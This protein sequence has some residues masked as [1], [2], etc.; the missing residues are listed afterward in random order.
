MK[1]QEK[2]TRFDR[3]YLRREVLPY[4]ADAWYVAAS[5]KIGY[6]I[7]FARYFYK[8]EPM[9][10]LEEIRAE[11][12]ALEKETEGLLDDIIGVVT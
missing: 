6:E 4:A 10:T 11:I 1:S 3:N 9:R 5:V 8:P 7:S 2:Q 12:L